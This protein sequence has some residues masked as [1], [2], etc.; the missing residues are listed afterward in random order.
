[1]NFD[2]IYKFHKIT[3]KAKITLESRDIWLSNQKLLNDPFEGITKTVFPKNK[4]ELITKCIKYMTEMFCYEKG[5]SFDRARDIVLMQYCRDQDDFLSYVKELAEKQHR[6][7]IDS[8]KNLGIYSTSADVPGEERS[9]IRN[10]IMWSLYADGFQGF[11]IKYNAKELYRSLIELNKPDKFTYTKVNYVTKPHEVDLF[12]LSDK[13]SFDYLRSLQCKHEQWRHEFE[14]RILCSST[15]SKKISQQSIE[16]VY[17]GEKIDSCE[18]LKM[19]KIIES[20]FPKAGIYK[21][22]LDDQSYGIEVGKKM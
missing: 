11:C 2:Y 21:V 18:E 13:N 4:E 22:K 7:S 8:I 15:G 3:D 6:L 12:S 10:M 1:M 16:G 17:F 5:M 9:H 19:I 20:S 14:C